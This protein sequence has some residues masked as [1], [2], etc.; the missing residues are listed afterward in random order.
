[1]EPRV[2][3]KDPKET[4]ASE[5]IPTFDSIPKDFVIIKGGSEAERQEF[6]DK[7][8]REDAILKTNTPKK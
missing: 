4:K 1:M 2:P 6:A 7:I 8:R 5:K 3:D